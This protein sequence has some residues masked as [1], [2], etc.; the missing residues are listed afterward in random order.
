MASI[1]MWIG[2]GL[3]VTGCLALFWQASRYLAMKNELA[4]FPQKKSR[5][6][7]NRQYCRLTILAGIAALLISLVI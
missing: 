3:I 1:L 7:L 2:I 4:K 5:L 6:L